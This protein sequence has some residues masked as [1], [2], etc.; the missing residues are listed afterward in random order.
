MT[1]T[2]RLTVSLALNAAL[3]AVQVVFGLAAHSVGLLAD[4]GHN[5]TDVASLAL[6]LGAVRFAMRPRSAERSFGNHRATILAALANAVAITAVTIVIVIEAVRRLGHPE[7]VDA[8]T[9]VVVAA[10]ALVV[11]GAAALLLRDGTADLNMRAALVHMAGDA[12]ASLAVLVS[13]AIL[14]AVPG[15]T[16]LDPVSALVVALIIVYEA[17]VV[18]RGSISVLLESTPSDVDLDRLTTAIG[19]VPGVVDVHDLH[20]WSLSGEVRALSAH[21]VLAGHP[22][23]EEAHAVGQQ[24]KRAITRPFGIAH[25]TLELECERCTDDGDPCLVDTADPGAAVGAHRH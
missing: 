18:F 13:A 14:I 25:S 8:G 4:A 3:V 2:G 10:A 12:L 20:V 1:R 22:T 6:S 9:V 19:G 24:V 16:W 17:A 23:L 11:N 7:H 5:V 15:A 21:L